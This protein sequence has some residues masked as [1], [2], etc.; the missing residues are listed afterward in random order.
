MANFGIKGIIVGLVGYAVMDAYRG[1]KTLPKS[2]DEIDK[3]FPIGTDIGNGVEI[4]GENLTE[5][6]KEDLLKMGYT[7]V[8]P[9]DMKD[10]PDP[11]TTQPAFN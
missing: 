1:L 5:A 11:G 6:Q 3:M 2:F 4:P 7:I 9:V 8:T 10:V